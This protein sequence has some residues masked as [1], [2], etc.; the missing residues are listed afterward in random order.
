MLTEVPVTFVT[1]RSFSTMSEHLRGGVVV[2][3]STGLATWSFG[4]AGRAAQQ[5]LLGPSV[6]RCDCSMVRTIALPR[7]DL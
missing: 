4:R 2:M 3:P 6:T 7:V 5:A 1:S